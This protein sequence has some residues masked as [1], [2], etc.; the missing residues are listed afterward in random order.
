[1][2]FKQYYL[3]CLSQ[4]SYLIG[5]T[6]TG[7]A[8]VVDP[9]RDVEPYLADAAERGLGIR[10]VLLTHFH[11]DFLAGHLELRQRT[12]ARLY[13]GARA[14]AEFPF[15]P[16]KDGR[17]IPLGRVC[18]EILE[19]PGHTP[20]SISI[21]VFDGDPGSHRP[22]AVLTGDTLFI[23]DVG[24]PDL[25]ASAGLSAIQL[26]EMLHQS[27]HEKLLTLPD[28]TLVY[29]GH[30]AGSLCGRALSSETVSTIGAQKLQNM[31]LRPMSREEFVAEVSSGQPD[32]PAYFAHD[33]ALNRR[34]HTTL[35]ASL[36]RAL[37]PLAPGV[38]LQQCPAAQV[39]DCRHP[40]Q[41]AANH[42]AG[43]LNIGLD[44]RYA[45]WAGT[46]LQHDRP[47]LLVTPPGQE[48]EAVVRLGRIGY[49]NVSGYLEG[50]IAALLEQETHSLKR[51]R[52]IDAVG[53]QGQLSAAR[54]PAVIDVR[55]P[56]EWAAGYIQGSLNH[57]L[58][59][60]PRRLDLLASGERL[61]VH[62]AT[63]YRSS[64]AAS[65]LAREGIRRL[66]ELEGGLGA[67]RFP[68]Q[69]A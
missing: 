35:E 14:K 59:Q 69:V 22:H 36:E 38:F 57:P 64:I 13:L 47:I 7:A 12:G 16:V 48:R 60:L 53:L 54:P 11:A 37:T 50:G 23:G 63:G 41:F 32:P 6:G 21:L 67:W 33:A 20:E 27:L 68:L 26:G 46:L 19:T 51:T 58:D 52:R 39:L 65:F 43:S 3:G 62:C 49:D 28:A 4:A 56:G 55:S 44:G 15:E 34:E 61:V 10:H 25:M 18:L 40:D 29:P 1:M 66:V 8:A 30:G 2:I 5:D 9:R 17:R 42:L 24:R 45:T 31:A